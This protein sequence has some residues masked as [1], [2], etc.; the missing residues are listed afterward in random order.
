VSGYALDRRGPW[1]RAVAH[2]QPAR[3]AATTPYAWPA[4]L[5]LAV[6]AGLALTSPGLVWRER[7]V[8]L[9]LSLV[10]FGVPH[11]AVDHL[12]PGWVAGRR[13]ARRATV[14][15][16][17]G[18]V[19]LTAGG[20]V[21]W[22]TCP[23]AALALFFGVTVLHWGSA[24]LAWVRRPP[25]PWAFVLARGAVPVLVPAIA[26]PGAFAAAVRALLVVFMSHPPTLALGPG[27]RVG[28]LLL[29]AAI[30]LRGAGRD[31]RERL[32][33]AG[34]LAFFALVTPVFA[35]GLYF[36]AWHSWR[37]I[38][39]LGALEPQAAGL[40]ADGRTGAAV[41]RIL[42]LA[43][44]CTAIALTGLAALGVALAAH[45]ASAPALTAVALAL[46]AALTVPHTVLVAWLDRRRPS[47]LAAVTQAGR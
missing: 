38:L 4:Y 45:L 27:W 20:L 37:H 22:M 30:C 5:T 9:L 23:L 29:L 33:L 21:L 16:L 34:L 13:L 18:Y 1:R 11:G 41:A 39:R 17:A 2:G 24:E 42:V 25:H 40:L 8:P 14:R 32:E 46:I 44:P 12:V 36:L 26:F 31:A 19:A 3:G 35:V 6:G 43:L 7:Y 47:A 10:V 15:L 28:A